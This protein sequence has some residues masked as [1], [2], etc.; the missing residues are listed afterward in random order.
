M[1]KKSKKTSRLDAFYKAHGKYFV[2]PK[3]I[4][5]PKASLRIV[6]RLSAKK[7]KSID[8]NAEV[9][10][11]KILIFLDEFYRGHQMYLSGRLEYESI[12]IH[13][14]KLIKI[15]G[16][17][18][19]KKALE[20][21]YNSDI[22]IMHTKKS[23]MVGEFSMAYKLDN[24]MMLKPFVRY[25]ILSK[26]LQNDQ[27]IATADQIRIIQ[28]NPIAM[29]V[30]K[31]SSNITL[32]TEPE[33][34][35][36][37]KNLISEGWSNK[38]KTLAFIKEKKKNDRKIQKL[39]DSGVSKDELPKY[40]YVENGIK[41]YK[42]LTENGFMLPKIGNFKSGGR[43]TTS[44]TLM[45]KWIRIKLLLNNRKIIGVDYSALHPNIASTKWGKSE[46]IS[47]KMIAN[48]LGMPIHTAKLEH[49]KFF[50]TTTTGME[51]MTIYTYY[52]KN[53]P[54]LLENI[55][56]TKEKTYKRTSALMFEA[57][58]EIMTTVISLLDEMNLSDSIIYVY[59]EIMTTPENAGTVKQVME[60]V[61][62]DLNY[63]LKAKIG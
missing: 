14:D 25:T 19:Y 58:V 35:E 49:L 39:K 27:I 10:R 7:L 31:T 56:K 47:H 34:I 16:S 4:M 59:D 1:K 55:K 43:V 26:K 3:I 13:S 9:A 63:N 42:S 40:Y 57:E 12:D 38:G 41:L 6:Q 44:F 62:R 15:F 61:A 52:E 28:D 18:K 5:V 33:L 24:E 8:E 54:E 60:Q 50:N 46:S 23:Y 20:F 30:V 32:R 2:D 21:M 37:A 51:K 17:R 29:S 45:P 48:S 53:Q 11:E 22:L 36:H